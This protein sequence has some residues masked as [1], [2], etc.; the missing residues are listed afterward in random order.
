MQARFRKT[1]AAGTRALVVAA[2]HPARAPRFA[3]WTARLAADLA[4]G[5]HAL[6]QAGEGED[7]GRS[8]TDLRA[9]ARTVVLDDIRALC[10]LGRAIPEELGTAAAY[11]KVGHI[12][13]PAEQ[14]LA[15]GHQYLAFAR[16]HQ[17]I[18][19]GYGMTPAH[20]DT[21]A[22]HLADFA[23]RGNAQTRAQAARISAHALIPELTTR[24]LKA[25]RALSAIYAH[26]FAAHPDLLA[27]WRNAARVHAPRRKRAAPP[28]PP[29]A[30][31]AP[32]A[33][34]PGTVPLVGFLP[35]PAEDSSD[36]VLRTPQKHSGPTFR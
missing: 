15:R 26:E 24:I 10:R 11:W 6:E 28:P 23:A 27:A 5:R 7:S 14:L 21:M 12:T 9:D 30:P 13:Q 1:L 32:L 19:D 34:P 22:A 18:L 2:E 3:D 16:A 35:L 4:A 33:L 36:P 17:E 31:R 29:D 8:A 25:L 20:L